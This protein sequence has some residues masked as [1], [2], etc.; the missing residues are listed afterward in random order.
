MPTVPEWIIILIVLV[1]VFTA[2]RLPAIGNAIGRAVHGKGRDE[3]DDAPP[4]RP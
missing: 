2:S 1:I 3:D 4:P